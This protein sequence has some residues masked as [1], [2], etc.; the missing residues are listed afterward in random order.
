M[1][2]TKFHGIPALS[3]LPYELHFVS[4]EWK[5]CLCLCQF[6]SVIT[7]VLHGFQISNIDRPNTTFTTGVN[8]AS[9][10][11]SS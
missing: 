1:G 6:L 5:V 9:G 8:A 11:A 3:V 2:Y 10:A 4:S 7:S